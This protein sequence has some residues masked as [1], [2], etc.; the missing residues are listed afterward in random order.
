LPDALIEEPAVRLMATLT[1][2][3][4]LTLPATAADDT[5]DPGLILR[6]Y[7]I[8]QHVRALPELKGDPLPNVIKTIPSVDLDNEGFAPLEDNFL[9]EITGYLVTPTS[10]S[11]EFRLVSDDGARFWLD[12]EVVVDHDGLHGATPKDGQV[13]LSAGRHV[14]RIRHFDAGA[15]AT[16]RVLWKP[17]GAAEDAEFALVPASALAHES[18]FE[19]AT[20]G[21]TKAIIPPLR[22][23]R[24]GDGAPVAGFHPAL[25]ECEPKPIDG[26]LEER[27][28]V[29]GNGMVRPVDPP[30]VW[31]PPSPSRHELTRPMT[32][33]I[34]PYEEQIVVGNG[35]TGSVARIALDEVAGIQQG[36]SFRFSTGHRKGINQVWSDTDGTLYVCELIPPEDPFASTAPMIGKYFKPSGEVPF[37]MHHIRAC[38]DGLE[39]TFTKPLDP[40]VGWEADS[41]YVEQWPYSTMSMKYPQRDGT[42][43]PVQSAHVYDDRKT[44]FLKINDLKPEHL[45]YVRLLPPCISEDGAYPWSTEAW[46]TLHVLP[47]D[48]HGNAVARPPQPPQNKLSQEE[49]DAGWHLLFDGESTA[50]WRGYGKDAFPDGWQVVDGCLV[51]VGAGG[52]IITEAEFDDFELKLDW[53][54]SAGG[55]SGIFFRVD[56]VKGPAYATG[57]EMQVLDN[58]EHANGLDPKTSAGAD[59]ALHAPERDVTQPIGLFNAVR[60][61]AKG[62]HVEYWLNGE[63]IVSYEIGSEDWQQRVADSKFSKMPHFGQA[64]KGHIVLQDH[65]DK[66]WYRNIKIRPLSK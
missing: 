52:D 14:L 39:I 50:G 48:R 53:R 22:V 13:D 9:T 42:R 27:V 24:P 51:R 66:V 12:G 56:E 30:L 1:M 4:A 55:N 45:V 17:P 46:Y 38:A 37:E 47:E 2:M 23:G 49:Q 15:D 64:A 60:I 28:N 35:P 36:A 54:I 59:Y 18:G 65:G 63:K 57:P 3:L 44:V 40:R 7:D 33:F 10:G 16:L 25:E 20:A 5:T 6:L 19:T 31:F 8:G 58:V 61:V 11:Y 34:A 41:Y 21:G 43:T 62:P 26:R 32:L 29:L